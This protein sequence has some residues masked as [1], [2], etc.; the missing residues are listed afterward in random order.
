MGCSCGGCRRPAQAEVA[1]VAWL[2]LPLVRIF[3]ATDV[4]SSACTAVLLWMCGASQAVRTMRGFCWGSR[5]AHPAP[6]VIMAWAMCACRVCLPY[7][8]TINHERPGRTP[9]FLVLCVHFEPSGGFTVFAHSMLSS[10]M[11]DLQPVSVWYCSASRSKAGDS[12]TG[13][14]GISISCIETFV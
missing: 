12:F 6:H 2:H 5:T 14:L 1:G 9:F 10:G 4:C 11:I 13:E 3:E 7:L 8:H